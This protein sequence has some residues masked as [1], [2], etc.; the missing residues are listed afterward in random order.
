[1]ANRES[2]DARE[3]WTFEEADRVGPGAFIWQRAETGYSLFFMLP[4]ED[5]LR[6]ISVN[7]GPPLGPRV[8]G[9]NGNDHSP[10]LMPS[11]LAY[12]LKSAKAEVWHGYLTKGRFISC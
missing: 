3:C 5:F 6:V 10:T 7:N 8:W 11:I 9:W 4:G 2:V 12:D 1:M